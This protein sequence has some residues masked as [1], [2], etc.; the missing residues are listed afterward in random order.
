[1][2]VKK[3]SKLVLL[4]ASVL[5]SAMTLH[6]ADVLIPQGATWKYL[7]NGTDQGSS[8]RQ[9]GFNDSSWAS[10]PAELGYGDGG[11]ATTVASGP[12]SDKF[13][14]T[15]FRHTFNVPNPAAYLSL[16][17]QVL[18][19]D[20]VVV[21]LNG[22]EVFRNNMPGGSVQYNTYASSALGGVDETTFVDQPTGKENLVAGVNVMAVE[23][24]QANATSS[25]I[26]FDLR[27]TGTDAALV[28]RGPYLQQA[29]PSS[30]II[31]WR[32]DVTS[33]SWVR[34]GTDPGNLTLQANNPAVTSEHIVSLSGLQP[35]TLYY[36]E[37]GDGAAWFEP[38]PQDYFITPPPVGTPQP[39]RIWVVGDSGTA[40][41][42][43]WNVQNAYLN[44]AA[45]QLA[46]L[47]L[48]LGDNAYNNGTDSEYQAAVFNMYTNILPNT[49]LWTTRGNHE[50]DVGGTGSSYYNIF[51]MPTAGEAGGLASG[52]EAY[53]SFDYAN[54]HFVCL[55]SQGSS[56][57]ST[58]TMATWLQNDLAATT[59][60]W[61][62]AF[63][64]HPPYTKGSH[65][66]DTEG[67][68]VEMRQNFLPI[69]EGAGVDLVLCGH[70]HSYERSFLLDG[71]YGTSGT[72]NSSMI[73]DPGSGR[74]DG[75]GAYEKAT[76]G[77]AAHEGAVYIVAGNGGKISGGSLNHTAMFA[78]INQLGSVVLDV[79][80]NRLD[81]SFLRETGAVDD[82]FTIIKGGAPVLPP[83]P[84][85]NLVASAGN[86]KVDLSWNPSA[87]ADAYQIKRALSSGGPYSTIASQAG[88]TAY[89]DGSVNNGTTYYYV[90]TA[91]NSAGESLPSNEANAT[92]ASASY[93]MAVSEIAI[94]GTVTGNLTGT[95]A[96][97]DVY[98]QIREVESGGKPSSRHSYLEHKWVLNV[99]G[100]DAVTFFL[101]AFR[102]SNAENDSFIFAYSTDDVA[103][104]DMVTV[105]KTSD[106]NTYQSFG[107]PPAVSGTL[108]IRVR[109]SNRSSGNNFLDT[110]FIDHL[111]ILSDNS[112]GNTPPPAPAGLSAIPGDGSVSL[113]WMPSGGATSYN[114]KRAST[115]GGLYAAIATGLTVTA[116]EDLGLQNGSTYYYV[117]TASNGVGT[118]P[119][120][121]EASA[122]PAVPNLPN[123]PSS[124]VASQAGK[125]KI[126]LNW[127]QS[128][129]AG[130]TENIIYRSNSSGGTYVPI[131]SIPAGTFYQD[132]G[133]NSGSTYYYRVTAVNGSGQS[134]PSNIA[135]ETAK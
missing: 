73:L 6:A 54:I 58:G 27:L 105:N 70:S 64:H 18:R 118:S 77:T 9:P 22:V 82:Y 113:S 130:I 96:T 132:G 48:M 72:L 45:G 56:R 61:I 8:W 71:H 88:S 32:T 129:S 122:T 62:I 33:E 34:Y 121:E 10:G 65:N 127:T 119:N 11:E 42:N 92:P 104:T 51:T 91:E 80:G 93:D 2:I 46:D 47:W 84:P 102:T 16:F 101:E 43:A 125:R 17:L 57:S 103:Y 5:I 109:D 35:N 90:V 38:E 26:S 86:G 75:D 94:A 4:A 24:H 41:L 120:S 124:L 37:L 28:T 115:S 3:A 87:G 1:M 76:A 74:E 128:N 100:G 67:Q 99:A 29:T 78:S 79:D 25:D 116:F 19:D 15:Y 63:W 126:A 107:L 69:L 23:I 55:D 112:N 83:Q 40:D 49:T 21:Y 123:P 85:G 53:Y 13:V 12:S 20:G 114:V 95:W 66:S 52:T 117:V 44:A 135:S 36:Y 106:D 30:I 14:T 60:N 133:L 50:S 7:D 134:A 68:L 111:F 98:E 97:D 59:Q 131:Q 31:R 89:S 108:Y 110:L 39:T 81:A